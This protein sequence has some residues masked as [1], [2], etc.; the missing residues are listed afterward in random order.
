MELD[1]EIQETILTT[2]EENEDEI[3]SLPTSDFRKVFWNQQVCANYSFLCVFKV[4][5]YSGHS[6]KG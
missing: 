3:K 5:I 4:L 1:K 2:I 6:F